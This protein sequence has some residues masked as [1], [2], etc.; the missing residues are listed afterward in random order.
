M[1]PWGVGRKKREKNGRRKEREG[2]ERER[3]LLIEYSCEG[4]ENTLAC[5]HCVSHEM[6]IATFSI[7]DCW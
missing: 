6:L 5:T 3:D 2:G 1:R 4:D 7:L